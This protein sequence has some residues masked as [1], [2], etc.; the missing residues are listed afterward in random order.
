MIAV[1]SQATNGV[2]GDGMVTTQT[3][4]CP[5]H[6]STAGNTVPIITAPV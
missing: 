3:Q 4:S 2:R 1:H 5:D 6:D